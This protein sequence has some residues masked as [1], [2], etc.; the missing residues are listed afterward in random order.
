MINIT[1]RECHNFSDC[2]QYQ[3][4]IYKDDKHICFY[5]AGS[6]DLIMSFNSMN[7]DNLIKITKDDYL[8]YKIVEKLYNNIV[9]ME[10][11]KERMIE[12]SS[13]KYII[14]C[15]KKDLTNIYDGKS[16]IWK[17]DAPIEDNTKL[18]NYLTITK[19]KDEYDL[20]FTS[21]MSKKNIVIEF[22]TDR[23]RYHAFVWE[24]Y[25][26]LNDLE[27]I[28]EPFRQIE[29]DEYLNNKKLIKK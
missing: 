25:Q 4:E 10:V 27:N 15:Y 23:S 11:Y 12:F 1:R 22:N 29:M 17:S 21:D 19:E 26:L 14:D 6:R 28:T 18:Y 9:N 8:I 2:H 5:Q 24:F 7:E 13:Y 20:I 16:I 3:Y